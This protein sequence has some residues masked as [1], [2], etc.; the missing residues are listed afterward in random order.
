MSTADKLSYW[1]L[2]GVKNVRRDKVVLEF[3][4]LM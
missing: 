2:T 3:Q 4:A 1:H